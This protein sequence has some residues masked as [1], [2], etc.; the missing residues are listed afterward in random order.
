MCQQC[1]LH[2]QEFWILSRRP[3]SVSNQPSACQRGSSHCRVEHVRSVLAWVVLLCAVITVRHCSQSCFC[4]CSLT[5]C[6][7]HCTCHTVFNSGSVLSACLVHS[8]DCKTLLPVVFLLFCRFAVMVVRYK[9][10]R[11]FSM[12]V[13]LCTVTTVT[14][15][16]HFRSQSYDYVSISTW[17]DIY[18]YI[19]T[20]VHDQSEYDY[21]STW[22]VI[23]TKS[24]HDMYNQ[25]QWEMTDHDATIMCLIVQR[26]LQTHSVLIWFWS[27]R[28]WK[29]QTVSDQV[30]DHAM[31][32]VGCKH[33]LFSYDSDQTE[34]HCASLLPFYKW[35]QHC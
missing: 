1:G 22:S 28:S 26:R 4:A 33:I 7:N 35:G 12:L 14:G 30:S 9:V 16:N 29:W 21:I 8:N 5:V 23:M 32:Y 25:L 17:S 18:D 20:S 11:C 10:A 2:V 31:Y 27:D 34:T 19:Y 13:F 15:M 6:S 24:V 3:Q